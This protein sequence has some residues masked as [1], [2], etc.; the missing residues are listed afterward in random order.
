[1]ND[2]SGEGDW[3]YGLDD[4][5]DDSTPDPVDPGDPTVESVAFV[6]LGALL[7][8]FVMARVAGLV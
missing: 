2:E 1:M 3:E 4:L 8:L 7:T 6:L 5:E